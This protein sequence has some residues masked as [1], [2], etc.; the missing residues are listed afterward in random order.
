MVASALPPAAGYAS[1]NLRN[2]L[3][4][5]EVIYEHLRIGG[6]WPNLNGVPLFWARHVVANSKG[7]GD[8]VCLSVLRRIRQGFFSSSKK[9]A[10]HTNCEFSSSKSFRSAGPKHKNVENAR[11]WVRTDERNIHT[12]SSDLLLN[13]KRRSDRRSTR[14]TEEG[15][16]RI[17]TV[18]ARVDRD[19]FCFH[20]FSWAR[21]L[22]KSSAVQKG[23]YNMAP[24]RM[25]L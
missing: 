6:P 19:D 5:F 15:F 11:R 16:S 24:Y 12:Q 17:R 18:K 23:P 10:N 21:I 8:C 1:E 14:E 25:A 9:F 2:R 7:R 22:S 20:H 4:G 13:T 3:P